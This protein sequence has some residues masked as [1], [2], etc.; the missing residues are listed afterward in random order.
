MQPNADIPED[1][2]PLVESAFSEAR[3]AVENTGEFTMGFLVRR[4]DGT[5]EHAHLPDKWGAVLND[6][7][8]KELMFGVLR[9]YI[10]K[11]G[12]TAVAILSDT[13]VGMPTDKQREMAKRSPKELKRIMTSSS[14]DEIV[15]RGL[16]ERSEAITI[17]VQTA[18]SVYTITH[19]YDRL[20]G[21]RIRWGER[22]TIH[23]AQE[24]FTGRGK[25]YGQEAEVE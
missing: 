23:A 10:E 3:R 14:F 1:L 8:F 6:G 25:M 20:K 21:N 13:W 12:A 17:M 15:K 5:I 24:S 19:P 18:S 9:T 7:R 16:A 11:I 22:Q 4:A 2:L